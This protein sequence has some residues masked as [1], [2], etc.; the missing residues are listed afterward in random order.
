VYVA[1]NRNTAVLGA[2]SG[3][4]QLATEEPQSFM[5][6]PNLQKFVNDSTPFGQTANPVYIWERVTSDGQSLGFAIA[7]NPFTITATS[8]LE[9]HLTAFADNAL[10]AQLDLLDTA[11]NTI[12]STPPLGV[13]LTDGSMN[14]NTGVTVETS[15]P[16]NWQSIR[17]YSVATSPIPAGSYRVIVSFQ[18]MNY[19]NFSGHPNPAG[20]SFVADIYQAV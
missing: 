8:Q 3:A 4:G 13:L 10:E 1:A 2:I 20:L 16:Y 12:V 7:S 11:T 18:V 17:Y 14:P 15:P 6:W 19:N 5:W 9:I